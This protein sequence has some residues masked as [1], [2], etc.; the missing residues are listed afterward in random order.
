MMRFL[1]CFWRSDFCSF[2][3]PLPYE[4]ELPKQ[5]TVVVVDRDG[6]RLSRRFLPRREIASLII[7][8]SSMPNVFTCGFI[9]TASAIPSPI[10][11]FMLFIP[12]VPAIKA[13]VLLN[14]MGADL[15][16][17]KSLVS[18][19]LL[20]TCC[21]AALPLE[22]LNANFGKTG[23]ISSLDEAYFLRYTE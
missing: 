13:F 16:Q 7:L 20:L 22:C 1:H 9:W 14:A 15:Y 2:L 12:A 11:T 6:S 19:L 5:Q 23:W 3:Y 4:E 10:L 8:L 17:I 18:H 21:V